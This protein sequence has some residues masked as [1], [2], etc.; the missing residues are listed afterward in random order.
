MP[1]AI[2]YPIDVR[3][4]GSCFPTAVH[5]VGERER[6]V[7]VVGVQVDEVRSKNGTSQLL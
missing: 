2:Y 7:H 3:E 5:S 4:F 1:G 6:P